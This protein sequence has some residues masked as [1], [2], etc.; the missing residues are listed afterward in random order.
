MSKLSIIMHPQPLILG[1]LFLISLAGFRISA[2]GDLD[3]DPHV[4]AAHVLQHPQTWIVS[5]GGFNKP[6]HGSGKALDSQQQAQ[7]VLQPVIDVVHGSA[8]SVGSGQF[9]ASESV[10]PQSQAIRLLSHSRY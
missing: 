6:E 10:E 2:A 9:L 4:Q 5:S 3:T 7:R 8:K 1:T